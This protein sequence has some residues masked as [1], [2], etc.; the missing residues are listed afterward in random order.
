MKRIMV[1]A[2]A[3]LVVIG[4]LATAGCS[5]KQE[6]DRREEAQKLFE[7]GQFGPAKQLLIALRSN[8]PNDKQ[9]LDLEHQCDAKIAEQKYDA[10]WKEA[11]SKDDYQE[12]IKA[13]IRMKEVENFNRDMVKDR[14]QKATQK[15][16]DAGARQL[17]DDELLGLL[18][19]L[20]M[21]YQVISD[22]DRLMYITMFYN[23]GRFPLK[24]WKDTFISKYPE[25]LDDN[26]MF[27]GYPRPEKPAAP[28]KKGAKP[29]K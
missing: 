21:R 13:M 14:I 20:Y 23:E 16:I 7:Q 5:G 25:L 3:V 6:G 19:K 18:N 4:L 27:V 28:E 15:A 29:A 2:L 9:L 24:E 1:M 22:K 26:N 12:W 11:E 17:K 8:Y 10:I